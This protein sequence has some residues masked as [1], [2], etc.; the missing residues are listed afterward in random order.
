MKKSTPD[1]SITKR[2]ALLLRGPDFEK[3][4]RTPVEGSLT[5]HRP[6]SIHEI[7]R[8]AIIRERA[9]RDLDVS[10]GTFEEEDDFELAEETDEVVGATSFHAMLPEDEFGEPIPLDPAPETPPP[11]AEPVSSATQDPERPS[12]APQQMS[13]GEVR[14]TQPEAPQGSGH[15]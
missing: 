6:P 8:Q 3:L 15:Q 7:V 14:Q 2:A 12:A 4:D 9:E 11:S 13:E 5:L 1:V 10:I